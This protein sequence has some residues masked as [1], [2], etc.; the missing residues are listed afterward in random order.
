MPNILLFQII[1][2]LLSC[3][4]LDMSTK[5]AEYCHLFLFAFWSS[6]ARMNTASVV[7]LPRLKPY[8]SGPNML[9]SST[10][11]V[12]FSHILVVIS[13]NKFEGTVM[14]LN[15]NN[16]K[17]VNRNHDFGGLYL[18]CA[19]LRESP[20]LKIRTHLPIF[21]SGGMVPVL[22]ILLRNIKI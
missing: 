6:E 17:Q 18:Y 15:I 2:G 22:M 9:F 11:L 4:T 10:M 20:P 1:F 5:A 13:R 21:I 19:G 16:M 14:G 12:I 8:C 7:L 3:T